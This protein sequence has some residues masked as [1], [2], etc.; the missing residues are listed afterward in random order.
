[1]LGKREVNSR[2]Y[3]SAFNF[4]GADQQKKVGT[5]SGGERNR[6]HLAK[7]LKSGANV[8]LLDEPTNDLDVDTLRALEEA[9]EDFA[10]CA[11]IISH[12]PL[13]PRP[14]RD[15]HAG[16]RGWT[17]MSSGSRANFQDYEA[18]KMRR[19]GTDFNHPAPD[20][21]QEV[22]K[23]SGARSHLMIA[24]ASARGYAVAGQKTMALE[25]KDVG[26]LQRALNDAS[27][28]ASGLWITFITFELYLAIAFGSVGHRDLFLE[29]PIKLPVL[30]V[31]LSMLGFF[32]VRAD[33]SADFSFLRVSAAS[34]TC[35]EGEGL[36]Y[37][38]TGGGARRY[39]PAISPSAPGLVLGPPVSCR[40][41]GAARRIWRTLTAADRMDYARCNPRAHS[42]A[43]PGYVSAVSS[44]G[45]RLA[46]TRRHHRRPLI[47]LVL[48]ESGSQQRRCPFLARIS[49]NA[50]YYA[51]AAASVCAF[52][53][54]VTLATFPGEMIYEK[55]PPLRVIPASINL[56]GTSSSRPRIAWT[57]LHELLFSGAVDDVSGRPSQYVLEPP[58]SSEPGLCGR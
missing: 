25:P 12:D 30:N 53:F 36:R 18:D 5:L 26:E 16:L 45:G 41:G 51:G 56:V 28:K 9:L 13:V 7:M 46:A 54:S 1:M 4:K 21:V 14:H 27:G 20:Q 35:Q 44:R 19:L 33:G 58:R 38:A 15:P 10:G 24:E 32:V 49:S 50:W 34:C 11:V 8:L 31:E 37:A 47:D 57:S 22:C 29:T 55:L 2:G 40:P 17:A 39:G 3:C 52:L 48:L 6:V 42:P 23:V 43:G